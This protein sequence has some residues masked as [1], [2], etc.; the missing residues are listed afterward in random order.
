[1]MTPVYAAYSVA[2]LGL[3]GGAPGVPTVRYHGNA[4][5]VPEA[6]T[7]CPNVVATKHC[8]LWRTFREIV[9]ASAI[10]VTRAAWPTLPV[11]RRLPA[12]LALCR[13]PSK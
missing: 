3:V 11:Q 10:R 6:W 4:V 5:P 8:S 7:T 9:N 13:A 2:V 1:M 12:D